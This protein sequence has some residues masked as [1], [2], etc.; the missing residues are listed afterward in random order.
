MRNTEYIIDM[1]DCKIDTII[2]VSRR[3]LP[4]L[5]AE[6]VKDVLLVFAENIMK[7]PEKTD[8]RDIWKNI[9]KVILFALAKS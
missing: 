2:G 3:V 4:L 5:L 6:F 9:K 8:S 7:Q 1:P